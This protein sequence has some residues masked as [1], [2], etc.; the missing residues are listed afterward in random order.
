[1]SIAAIPDG[2]IT[3][4]VDQ[5]KAAIDNPIGAAVAGGVAGLAVGTA[6]GIAVGSGNSSSGKKRSSR[7]RSRDR[8]FISKQR[9]EKA[10]VKKHGAR[11]R[12]K[13][14]SSK[15]K[16]SKSRRGVHY[17]RVT[18]QPYIILAS[19]KAKFIKGKRRK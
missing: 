3:S 13:Y 5:V 10:Y 11:G 2:S 19:G 6:L 1:M 4:L 12:K 9:H 8:K 17:A 15:S 14:K 18:G 7:G 16:R